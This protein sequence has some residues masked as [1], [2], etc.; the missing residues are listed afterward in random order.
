MEQLY[1]NLEKGQLHKIEPK[2]NTNFTSNFPNV[3][4]LFGDITN[5]DFFNNIQ[6]NV[7]EIDELNS[8][9]EEKKSKKSD[10]SN[11][12]MDI[13]VVREQNNTNKST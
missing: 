10:S 13:D 12:L 2:K 1:N 4:Q 3:V 5:K 11:S 9:N 8:D 6:L 7:D